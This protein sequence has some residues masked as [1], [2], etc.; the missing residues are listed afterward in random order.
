MPVFNQYLSPPYTDI[1]LGE[2]INLF[3]NEN[4]AAGANSIVIT[5]GPNPGNDRGISFQADFT[6]AP[7][8]T[9]VIMGSNFVPTTSPQLGQALQTLT[10]A[11][12]AVFA[13]NV[14]F[15]FYWAQV[16]TAGGNVNVV[17]QA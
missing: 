2:Q 11:G 4:P 9:V 7:T 3:A 13:P 8:G 5:R 14:A 12:P 17:A 10:A 16:G 15:E 6:N 1:R